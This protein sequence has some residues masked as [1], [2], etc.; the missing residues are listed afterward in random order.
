MFSLPKNLLCYGFRGLSASLNRQAKGGHKDNIAKGNKKT[1]DLFRILLCEKSLDFALPFIWLAANYNVK[2]LIMASKQE[3]AD[4]I[5]SKLSALEGVFARK[6]FGEYSIYYREKVVAMLCDEM[7]FVKPTAAGLAFLK[8]AEYAPPYAGAK[9]YFLIPE[10]EW[11]DE[12]RLC[13][14]IRLSEP[15]IKIPVKRKK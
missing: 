10:D 2:E 1:N 7:L 11:E 5:L 3:T 8:D 15:E 12:V 9:D 13:E 4:Y 14:L 6:M